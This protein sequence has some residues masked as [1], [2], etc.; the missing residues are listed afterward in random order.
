MGYPQHLNRANSPTSVTYHFPKRREQVSRRSNSPTQFFS[1]QRYP[2]NTQKIY[3]IPDFS[4][5]LELIG[6]ERHMRGIP[7]L[8]LSH[9]LAQMAQTH[10]QWMADQST[11]RRSSEIVVYLSKLWRRAGQNV[12]RSSSCEKAHLKMMLNASD[13]SRIT[14][15]AYTHVGV[16]AARGSDGTVY[17]CQLFSA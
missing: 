15:R 1:G 5:F 13:A 3:T 9:D 6:N 12:G 8:A 14:D 7:Q 4:N 11:V 2:R 16:G 10:A 17:V